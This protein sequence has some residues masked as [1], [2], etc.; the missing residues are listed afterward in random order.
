MRKICTLTFILLSSYLVHSQ[1]MVSNA[2]TDGTLTINATVTYSSPYMYTVWIKNPSGSFLRT[3]IMYG[4]KTQYYT[5]LVHWYSESSTNKVNATTGATRTSSSSYS[6]IWNA[7][8]Q[9]NASIV[10][11]G[12]YTVSIEMTSEAY[13]TS[14][15]YVTATFNKGTSPVTITPT[16]ISPLS[17]ITIQWTPASTGINSIETDKYTIYPNPTRS[18]IYVN[19]FDIKTVD[20]LMLNGKLVMSA[21]SQHLNLSSLPKGIYLIKLTTDT[22]IY[23][24]KIEKI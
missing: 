22:G 24:K 8:D 5:D 12:V 17:N 19:G 16:A 6:A 20:V 11:D 1:N 7:K 2:A 9:A 18:T 10:S 15:K 4:S 23:F 14:S 21:N 3:L 13:G